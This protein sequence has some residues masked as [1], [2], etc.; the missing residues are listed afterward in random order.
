MRIRSVNFTGDDGREFFLHA[1]GPSIVFSNDLEVVGR[2]DRKE[3]AVE[4]AA[5]QIFV[6][7]NEFDP[8]YGDLV[9]YSSLLKLFL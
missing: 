3:E 8:T 2:F 6:F 5:R 7:V 4:E 9:E 1:K